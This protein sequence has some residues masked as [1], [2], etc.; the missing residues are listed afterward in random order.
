MYLMYA[1]F[2]IVARPGAAHNVRTLCG[3]VMILLPTSFMAVM[4]GNALQVSTL[5]WGGYALLVLIFVSWSWVV[6]RVVKEMRLVALNATIKALEL[7]ADS[8][9]RSKVLHA[10]QITRRS[11]LLTV[12]SNIT[13][14]VNIITWA[15]MFAV[16]RG[17]G[18]LP[19]VTSGSTMTA[20]SLLWEVTFGLD[21]AVNNVCAAYLAGYYNLN[22]GATME[23]GSCTVE[24]ALQNLRE[25]EVYDALRDAA[26][27]VSGPSVMLAAL[28]EGVAP[29]TLLENAVKKFRCVSWDVLKEHCESMIVEGEV[30]DYGELSH[31]CS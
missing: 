7:D 21:A 10:S 9:E 30:L 25:R 3:L 5:L 15:L 13:T 17:Y 11:Y 20:L 2:R 16:S 23:G 14:A 4:V 24:E 22:T 29:T 19:Q 12:A 27:G 18:T 28:F 1:R 31:V 8:S 6:V 26:K